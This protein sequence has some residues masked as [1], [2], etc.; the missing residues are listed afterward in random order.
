M[1]TDP[2]NNG[3]FA[4]AAAGSG[5]FELR[6][7]RRRDDGAVGLRRWRTGGEVG[8][9]QVGKS[10][11]R[12]AR[13]RQSAQSERVGTAQQFVQPAN[14]AVAAQRVCTETE[15]EVVERRAETYQIKGKFHYAS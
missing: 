4:F 14:V 12:V 8:I 2:E 15:L 1:K 10:S 5:I 7:G 6:V 3:K 13:P 11:S 9:G